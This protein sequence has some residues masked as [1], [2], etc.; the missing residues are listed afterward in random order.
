MVFAN[1]G[2]VSAKT[3]GDEILCEN[4]DDERPKETEKE[5]KARE[6]FERKEKLKEFGGSAS[7]FKLLSLASPAELL[8]LF[9]GVLAASAHG[10]GQ[11]VM[12]LM[13][14]DLI[15]ATQAPVSPEM[16]ANMSPAQMAALQEAF[17]NEFIDNIARIALKFTAIGAGV[18]V[19]ASLQGFCFPQF[20]DLQM[21][22]MRPLYFDAA[23]H[24]DVGWFDTHDAGALAAE[25]NDDLAL[26]ADGFGTKLGAS[27]MALGCV[28]AGMVIGLYLSWQISLVMLATF[29]L[30]GIGA[31]A[32]GQA[33]LDLQN[34]TQ[35]AY[36]TAARVADEVLFAV[37]T[38]V[39]FGAERRE[40]QRY[41]KSVE[42]ARKG[43]LKNRIK[44]GFG[45]GWIWLS[46]F[47]S[48]ALAFWYGMRL[49]Y[50][51]ADLSVGR[52]MSAF[53]CV[54]T[55]GFTM[56]QIGPGFGGL[57][58]ARFAMARFFHMISNDSEIEK[59]Q[60]D[61]R[62]NISAI[63]TMELQNVHFV[64]PARPTIKVL[65]G[66]SLS[67]GKG[68]K[69]AIVG[70]SGSGKST[71]M[72]LL[73]RFYDPTDG[74]VLVNGKDLKMFSVRS[75]R[76]CI[77]YVGQEPVLFATD[78]RSNIM[79][80]CP[81]ASDDDFKRAASVA[82]LDF[83]KRLPDAFET[84]V[85]SGGSQ[86]S[87]GQ[88]Q[89]I[90]IARALVK[91]PSL[92]FLDE[93][94]SALDSNS[95]KMMQDTIDSI[96][97]NTEL[98]ITIVAIAHRLSTVKNSDII[99]VLRDGVVHESGN[100]SE[101]MV[102]EGGTYKALSAAQET[103]GLKQLSTDE[104]GADEELERQV[105]NGRG[106]AGDGKTRTSTASALLEQEEQ[107][108]MRE[109]E[110]AKKYKVPL[111]R[112][113]Q[114]CKPERWVFAPGLTAALVKGACF[115][116]LSLFLVDAMSA[117]QNAKNDREK[118]KTEVERA[119]ILFLVVGLV[120]FV[121]SGL[122]FTCFGVLGEAITKRCRVEMLTSI[123][124]QDVGFHD[125]PKHTP[126]RLVKSLQVYAFRIAALC[127]TI[128]DKIDALCSVLVGVTI[129]FVACWQMAGAM[130]LSIPVFGAAQAIQIAVVMGG[131]QTEN[132]TMKT[133]AQVVADAL[134]NS[135]T[136]HALGNEKGLLSMYKEI[137][138]AA[139]KGFRKRN[140]GTGF[141]FGIAN[142]CMF[143]I[144]A[145]G[146]YFMGWL[147]KE[148]YT[149]FNGGM[150]AFMGI[151]YAAMGAGMA[152]AL[153]GDLA[154]AKVAAHDMFDILDTES[155]INGLEPKGSTVDSGKFAGRIE[156]D[157]IEFFYPFRPDVQVL[158]G[159]SFIVE[160]GQS[161]GICGPSGSGKSTIMAMIQRFYDPQRGSVRIGSERLELSILD[162]RWWRKQV[163]FVGQEPLLFDASVLENVK[164]GLD[165]DE[166]VSEERLNECKRMANLKFLDN[167][168]A[169]GW[170]TQVGNR[171]SRLSGGQKQRVAICRALV[172]N[173][174]ILLLDE[175]TS[176]LDTQSER[177]VAEALE[178]ARQ[179]RT[180]FSIAH[181][182][183]TI[184]DC[185]LLLVVAD[186]V[187][188]E[189][190]SHAE[191]LAARG[192]Y[193][194]LSSGG[195]R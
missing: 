8:L 190:G 57:Y 116:V 4:E 88:K 60:L 64:Y 164:Y 181:R 13:F 75:F 12:C 36:T 148:G 121:T 81:E 132:D 151:L 19:L 6:A 127:I 95:E 103:A 111:L 144:M 145:A 123:F 167:H 130:L 134:K 140:L 135:R 74:C 63:E 177:V 170:E 187:I 171:G 101:L 138:S 72:A 147:I 195:A 104:G 93:A 54:L 85:G 1:K 73:E 153:T 136:V 180:S 52:M 139:D 193:H 105:S 17:Q 182:L 161:V 162:I 47:A 128:G 53:F 9:V 25:M 191:L 175:A 155:K 83:I 188:V 2:V 112:L 92:L 18:L 157:D 143:W 20:V 117:F 34:E 158:K 71:V 35:G 169:Q 91:K 82:Q 122:Q 44:T 58:G 23:I 78:V 3:E 86:F 87:G 165:A 102:M 79:Q 174:P 129:A 94:T 131:A 56:G 172:R 28:V 59:R 11:P 69:V 38:V 26:F 70:E 43:G 150:R 15:D 97:S 98:G 142:A 67:I 160:A 159:M 39:S 66:L 114:F 118:M 149:D 163:G 90:A 21:Q 192:V 30:I 29:P 185:D 173:P 109:K 16:I 62:E 45:M 115:P 48:M 113:L 55:A 168:K 186:G 100:H 7:I 22:K 106:N 176:A 42:I 80:G 96:G 76:R 27:F 137:V 152:F 50:D 77:G 10:V 120:S 183:S 156:F 37:R 84:Y 89:R 49:I 32:M 40:L 146:F 179:N 14:G 178:A 126:G 61:N 141:A 5:K 99:Y 51:G 107:E 125:N 46:Y 108:T 184:Q 119:A 68:Q 110:V 31:A 166:T 33:I 124:R 24:R 133:A 194:K 154:K 189:R 65:N 41:E